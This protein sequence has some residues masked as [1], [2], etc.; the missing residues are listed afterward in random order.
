MQRVTGASRSARQLTVPGRDAGHLCG[1]I[2]HGIV[3]PPQLQQDQ[4]RSVSA[5]R[6]SPIFHA[7]ALALGIL[8][9][10]AMA[11]AHA[12]G[13]QLKENSVK[14]LGAAFAGSGVN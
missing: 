3:A 11:P 6:M 4:T 12:S 8:G 9:A 10:L 14:G 1:T 7:S 5:M 13:F 2:R